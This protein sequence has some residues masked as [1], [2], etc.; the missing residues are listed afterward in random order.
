MISLDAN[1]KVY[2]LNSPVNSTIIQLT[3]N[4]VDQL[5]DQLQGQPMTDLLISG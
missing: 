2:L 3:T 4:T 1:I 5:V